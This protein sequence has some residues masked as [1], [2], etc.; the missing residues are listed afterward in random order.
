M[1]GLQIW[2]VSRHLVGVAQM[3]VA[4]LSLNLMSWLA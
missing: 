2:K 4:R 1:P 3:H